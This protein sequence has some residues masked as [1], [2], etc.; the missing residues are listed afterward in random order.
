MLMLGKSIPQEE[1]DVAGMLTGELLDGG[2]AAGG[3]AAAAAAWCHTEGQ[4]A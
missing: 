1:L 4:E 2:A 3:T